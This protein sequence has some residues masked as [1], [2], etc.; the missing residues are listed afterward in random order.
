MHCAHDREP[1]TYLC[2]LPD[3]IKRLA[4]IVNNV[5][6]ILDSDRYPHQVSTDARRFQFILIQLS[7]RG[8][9]RMASQ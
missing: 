5:I 7:V 8:R 9:G 3:L 4:D 1:V 2:H 6:D